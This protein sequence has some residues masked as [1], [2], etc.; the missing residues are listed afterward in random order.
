VDVDLALRPR[1]VQV[2][3]AK[4][5]DELVVEPSEVRRLEVRVGAFVQSGSI[6]LWITV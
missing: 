1:R 4:P 5:V 6:K 2:E 3:L